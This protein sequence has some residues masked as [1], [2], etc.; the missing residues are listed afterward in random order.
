LKEQ[1][2]KQWEGSKNISFCEPDSTD[3]VYRLLAMQDVFIFPT[4]FEG[5]PVAILEC[6]ANGVVT[7]TNDLPGGIR[8]IVTEN[9]GFRCRLNNID[10]FVNNIKLLHT[11]IKTVAK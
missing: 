10:D 4:A 9:I 8:D 6:L 3:E 1:L 5:T 2:Y 7:I 11:N